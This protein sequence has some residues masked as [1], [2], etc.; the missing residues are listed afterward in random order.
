MAQFVQIKESVADH[1][2]LEPWLHGAHRAQSAQ[3][4][5]EQ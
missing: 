5:L 1:I 2:A 4:F 3:R